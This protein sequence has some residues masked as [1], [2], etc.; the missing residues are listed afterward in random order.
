MLDHRGLP[1]SAIADYGAGWH[2]HLDSL[3]AHVSGS[4]S[5]WST[6]F[7]E[8]DPEYEIRAAAL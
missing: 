5:D 3:D 8:L 4:Q 2:S 6:R 1:P 7:E